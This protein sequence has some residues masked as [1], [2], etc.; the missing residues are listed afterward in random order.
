MSEDTP[1]ALSTE[2]EAAKILYSTYRLQVGGVNEAGVG[3]PPWEQLSLPLHNAWMAVQETASGGSPPAEPAPASPLPPTLWTQ[4]E[5]EQ[6][7]VMDLR[8]LCT[9]N[10]VTVASSATKQQ[11]IDALLASQRPT[12]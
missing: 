12:P 10:N 11:L 6:L 3:M 5:L 9:D 1:A 2:E 7:T 4:E 8:E